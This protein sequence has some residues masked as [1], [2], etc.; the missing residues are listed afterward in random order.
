MEKNL[1]GAALL[2]QSLLKEGVEYVFAYPGGPV[3]PILK[4]LSDSSIE[5]VL[6]RHE[7]G[8][9]HMAD[10]YGRSSKKPGVVLVTSGPGATNTVTGIVT[11]MMDSVPLV[12]LTGQQIMPFLGKDAFQ[13]TDIFGITAPIVKHSYLI[14]KTQDIPRIIQEAFYIAQSGRPGPVLIDLP[15]D[16]VL[17]SCALNAI[18][19]KMDIPAYNPLPKIDDTLISKLAVMLS[20]SKRPVLIVGNGVQISGA[21]QEVL[22]LAQLLQIPVISSMLALGVFPQSHPLSMGFMGMYGHAYANYAALE[23]DFIVAIGC[24]F[25][26]RLVMN[27]KQ[28]FCPNATKV[29]I[30]IDPYE[31]NKVVDCDLTIAGDAKAVLQKLLVL[32]EKQ[33]RKAWVSKAATLKQK[34][35]LSY[36]DDQ[37]VRMPYVIDILY[38]QTKGEAIMVTDVGMHQIWA[39]QYYALEYPGRWVSSCGAG[40]MGYGLPAAIGVQLASK[41]ALVVAIV[42]DGGFQMMECELATLALNKLPIKIIVMDNAHLGMVLQLQEL[43]HLEA[44]EAVNLTG[45]PDFVQLAT[46]YGVKAYTIDKA[47]MAVA[48]IKRALAYNEGPCLIHV[49]LDEKENVYPIIKP[50]GGLEEM[51]FHD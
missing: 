3:L 33:D 30:D 35:S 24:S 40:T 32:I 31:F 17:R 39:A 22:H 29:H 8:A 1:S 36:E 12:V 14:T 19:R 34:F 50:G 37:Q 48:I 46:S 2:V 26:D 27:S 16:V 51:I 18:R 21:D 10:G 7:Q 42:G 13:E 15:K 23:S 44:P 4:V 47:D 11:A 49:K 41:E 20:E 5:T 38:K 45:N 6:V 43:V 9:V 25:N 28:S